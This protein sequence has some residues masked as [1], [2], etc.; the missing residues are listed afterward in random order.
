MDTVFLAGLVETRLWVVG[1]V[2]FAAAIGAFHLGL[3]LRRSSDRGQKL[4][5]SSHLVSALGLLALLLGFAFSIAVQR[6]EERRQL[7][8]AQANA[9]GSTYFAA[10]LLGP[11]HGARIGNLIRTYASAQLDLAARGYPV[12]GPLRGRSDKL[13]DQ[14]DAAVV[15]ATADSHSSAAITLPIVNNTIN[16]GDLDQARRASRADHVPMEVYLLLSLYLISTAGVLGYY[17]HRG[18]TFVSCFVLFLM[19][20]SLL[21]VMDIDR[22]GSG[23][24]REDQG[25]IERVNAMLGMH[26]P[27]PGF[28]NVTMK[29]VLK[30]QPLP[31]T[32]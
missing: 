1:V 26:V 30:S 13:L 11:Q 25:P 14:I 8:V 9:I 31:P 3:R 4:G 32:M 17:L 7:V 27:A 15:A 5:G 20:M 2:L 28:Q 24:I 10:Q 12:G 23:G 29:S 19:C 16:L 18:E 22:P 21:L 6:F